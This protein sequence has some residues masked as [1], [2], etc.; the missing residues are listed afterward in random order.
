MRDAPIPKLRLEWNTT[1]AHL[2]TTRSLCIPSRAQPP[3][4]PG[5]NG[6]SGLNNMG[7]LIKTAGTVT[8]KI[9]SYVCVDDGSLIQ[10]ISGR[11]G[12]MVKCPSTSIPVDVG[13]TVSATGVIEG[14]IPSGWTTNRRYIR[15]RDF[16]DFRE[17]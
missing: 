7:L 16:S 14:S 8:C 6:A 13:D 5:V 1:T 15:T 11:V 17:F 9:T 4:V 12:V 3:F 10:D 2:P